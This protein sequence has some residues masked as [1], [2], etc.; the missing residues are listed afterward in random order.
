MSSTTEAPRTPMSRFR[1]WLLAGI[2]TIILAVAGTW[3]QHY[4]APST[5]SKI[6]QFDLAGMK[7]RCN[8]KLRSKLGERNIRFINLRAENHSN[9]TA[10]RLVAFLAVTGYLLQEVLTNGEPLERYKCEFSNMYYLELVPKGQS[11]TS[12][13]GQT[14]R[15][16][17]SI[18]SLYWKDGEAAL[19]ESHVY[20]GRWTACIN[21]EGLW[22][23]IAHEVVEIRNR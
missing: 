3:A 7:V 2:G 16:Y 11:Q 22:E 10:N 21:N 20:Y 13:N 14:C 8:V 6:D 15:S 1:R 4:F 5:D 17:D 12:N 19:D 9:E 23:P 18:G